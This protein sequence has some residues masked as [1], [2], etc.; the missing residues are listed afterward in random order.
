MFHILR[1]ESIFS[2]NTDMKNDKNKK[3]NCLIR[4]TYTYF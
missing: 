1:N 2:N 3:I 4:H